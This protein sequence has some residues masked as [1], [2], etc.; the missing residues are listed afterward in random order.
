M[1]QCLCDVATCC[2]FCENGE[3]IY[4]SDAEKLSSF[5]VQ[6]Y[7]ATKH[8]YFVIIFGDEMSIPLPVQIFII[9]GAM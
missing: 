2:E 9:N 5:G 7:F 1:V 6:I 3:K 8:E 4:T